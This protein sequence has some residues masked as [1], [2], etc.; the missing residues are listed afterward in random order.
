[1]TLVLDWAPS[2]NASCLHV[3]ERLSDAH[4]FMREFLHAET[5]RSAERLRNAIHDAKGAW[6]DW[7]ELFTDDPLSSK[8]VQALQKHPQLWEAWE[9]F[10]E[11]FEQAFPDHLDELRLRTKVL[12]EA[13]EARGPG[14]LRKIE[15]LRR[16]P[17]SLEKVRILTTYPA[18][19]GGGVVIPQKNIIRIDGVL[20][21]LDRWLPETLRLGWLLLRLQLQRE[22]VCDRTPLVALPALLNAGEQCDLLGDRETTRRLLEEHWELRPESLGSAWEG[23]A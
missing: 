8:T 14:L 1:M 11:R 2:W 21:H 3:A 18:Q 5:Y 6:R 22:G 17:W 16:R 13:W 20:Y 12:R 10:R 9:D 23:I 19:S 4:S 7:T 15:Q